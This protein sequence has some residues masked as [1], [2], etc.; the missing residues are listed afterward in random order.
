VRQ[1]PTWEAHLKA[2]NHTLSVAHSK[3]ICLR[4]FVDI[5]LF[6]KFFDP[7]IPGTRYL[8]HVVVDKHWTPRDVREFAEMMAGVPSSQKLI[9]YEEITSSY[10]QHETRTA[11]SC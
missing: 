7:L 4:C 3:F 9:C 11:P 10:E 6:F 8:G 5:L 1:T 2:G